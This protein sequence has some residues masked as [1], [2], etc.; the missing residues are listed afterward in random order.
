MENIA[1][2]RPHLIIVAGPN[3]SGKSTIFPA[4]QNTE[5]DGFPLAPAN[6]K[7]ENFV[8]PDNIANEN[9][10]NEIAAGRK[11]IEK[12]N[13]LI[14]DG[15]D[16]A[17]ETTFSGKTLSKH[18]DYA[19]EKGYVIYII[20]LCLQS[21][22][23]SMNRVTQRALGGEHYIPLKRVLS[24][25]D[26]SLK[27]FFQVY[28]RYAHIWIVAD[29]SSL[30]VKPLYWGG[31]YYNSEKVYCLSLEDNYITKFIDSNQ[32]SLNDDLMIHQFYKRVKPFIYKEINKPPKEN[33]VVVQDE[34]TE[35]IK[36]VSKKSIK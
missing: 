24:R 2:R 7:T 35:K 12:I 3:G 34:D 21:S 11:T 1:N 4:L 20:F 13:R 6:I 23:L 14:K 19:D 17:I 8:N 31:R 32:L 29:N 27:N 9:N 26:K 18:L 22:E 36:F 28:K 15:E 10:L 16:L 33:Y 30:I 25:Y 5:R